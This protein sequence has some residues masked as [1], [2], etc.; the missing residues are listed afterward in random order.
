M[1]TG[2]DQF[3]Q[4]QYTGDNRC[5]PCTIVNI[6]IAAVGSTLRLVEVSSSRTSFTR[7]THMPNSDDSPTD[8]AKIEDQLRQAR[9]AVSDTEGARDAE[10]SDVVIVNRLY[11]A[12]FHAAQAVLYDRGYDP[13]SHGGVISL[14]GSEVVMEGDVPREM[15]RLLNR[16][17]DFRK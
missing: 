11:Y 8:A 4:S 3:Q 16:L 1:M 12:C 10:L 6:V 17:S 2:I 7:D 14:F 5:I 15:D 13:S 9:Q